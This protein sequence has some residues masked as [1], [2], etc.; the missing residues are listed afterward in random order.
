MH[1]YNKIRVLIITFLFSC[2]FRNYCAIFKE[3]FL[4]AQNYCIYDY[5]GLQLL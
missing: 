5:I 4:Y 2:M 3:N 1:I